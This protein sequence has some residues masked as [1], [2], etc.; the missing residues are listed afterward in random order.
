MEQLLSQIKIEVKTAVRELI[1]AGKLKEGSIVVIG[2]STS[3]VGGGIIGKSGSIEIA[4]AIY[5]TAAELLSKQ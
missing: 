4:E 5:S 3:E 1:M 2:C